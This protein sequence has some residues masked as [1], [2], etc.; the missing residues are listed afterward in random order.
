[1]QVTINL[2]ADDV[3]ISKSIVR[4]QTHFVLNSETIE[5]AVI[6]KILQ[7]VGR[8]TVSLPSRRQLSDADAKYEEAP[9]IIPDIGIPYIEIDYTNE[10]SPMG[11][12]I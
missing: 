9:P 2:S 12:N 5:D 1:M 6:T 3:R 10:D 4:N 7:L 8:T 11:E